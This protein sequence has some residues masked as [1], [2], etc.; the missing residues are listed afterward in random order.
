MNSINGLNKKRIARGEHI[1]NVYFFDRNRRA[2]IGFLCFLCKS[3][4]SYNLTMK[5]GHN[6]ITLCC[7]LF[8]LA[9]IVVQRRKQKQNLA[10][11]FSSFVS[12]AQFKIKFKR[13]SC[14]TLIL[15][16]I[17]DLWTLWFMYAIW[18]SEKSLPRQERN[19]KALFRKRRSTI[20]NF[21][22][23]QLNFMLIA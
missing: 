19:Q 7:A 2:I 3:I 16:S 4:T 15:K 21:F 23:V 1:Y 22:S 5:I 14:H 13:F 18:N 12:R 10:F 8:T 9:I 11:A 17:A 20:N 6:T